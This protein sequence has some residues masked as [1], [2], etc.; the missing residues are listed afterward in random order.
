[1]S[2]LP[3]MVKKLQQAM[4][5][6]QEI[7]QAGRLCEPHTASEGDSRGTGRKLSRAI[8]VDVE[9]TGLNPDRDEIVEVALILFVLE[10]NSGYVI[11]TIDEYSGLR[12][13]SFSI[14]SSVSAIH[15]ITDRMVK[16]AHLNY[17]KI[18]TLI[19]QTS[20]F[21]S[22]NAE[23]DYSF[24]VRLFPEI[25]E[26]PWLCSMR[27]INWRR[28]GYYSRK[29]EH[30][31]IM[32]RIPVDTLHRAKDDCYALLALLNQPTIEGKTY[33]WELLQ[34]FRNPLVGRIPG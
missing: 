9:T 6:K 8:V 27:Q 32:H 21:V 23:F 12:E 19:A 30:L 29:L 2:I 22:H 17:A 11:S 5:T 20:F 24:L 14:P 15:G 34:H 1:M 4:K 10:K 3:S 7:D 18:R 16:G 25:S 28:F 33:L 13:P 26:K 31:L